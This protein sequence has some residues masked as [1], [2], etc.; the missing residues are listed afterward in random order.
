MRAGI[1]TASNFS[2]IMTPGKKKSG[3][4]DGYMNLLLAERILHRPIETFTSEWMARGS[5]IEEKAVHSYEFQHDCETE[6]IGFVTTDDGSIGCSPDRFIIGQNG[7]LQVKA[8]SPQVHVSYLLAANGA[9]DEYKVQ[10]QSEIWICEKEFN[11]VLSFHPE[12]PDA[13]FRVYRD[14]SFITELAANVLSFARE[15]EEKSSEFAE[16]GWI[17]PAAEEE[18][19]AD[20]F[21]TQ[22]D[23]D[24][25]MNRSYDGQS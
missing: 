22:A 4:R 7:L 21:L 6:R 10:L 3:Q 25:A 2:K 1:P 8:P 11:E 20:P 12:M 13:L 5:E 14:E 19:A 18:E 23:I 9:G 17:K 16:R 24:W 15:L